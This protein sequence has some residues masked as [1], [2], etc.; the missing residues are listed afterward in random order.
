MMQSEGTCMFHFMSPCATRPRLLFQ[1]AVSRSER[2]II[3]AMVASMLLSSC[4]KVDEVTQQIDA[5]RRSI[6]TQSND[7]QRLLDDLQRKLERNA[8]ED[9]QAALT[10]VR[11]ILQEST[12]LAA[13]EMNCRVEVISHHIDVRL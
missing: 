10:E 1:G 11:Q 8:N 9:A 3:L 12:Q 6:I 5:T 7:W 4:S 13:Q 2:A